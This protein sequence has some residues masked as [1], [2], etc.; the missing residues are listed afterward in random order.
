M[1]H[2]DLRAQLAG[3]GGEFRVLLR[4]YMCEF[5]PGQELGLVVPVQVPGHPDYAGKHEIQV[6]G[7][8]VIGDGQGLKA[9]LF[10]AL[11]QFRGQ[12]HSIGEK[13]MAV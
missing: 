9:F 4:G 7:I 3:L 1:G 8:H 11:H 6:A 5:H 10:G 13:G 12:Q 2:H